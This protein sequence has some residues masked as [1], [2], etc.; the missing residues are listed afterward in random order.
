MRMI[1]NQGG[2]RKEE[3]CLLITRDE[4]K[5]DKVICLTDKVIWLQSSF[6]M[7]GKHVDKFA[8]REDL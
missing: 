6:S 1:K 8:L 4:D 3:Q 2:S 7:L 5:A